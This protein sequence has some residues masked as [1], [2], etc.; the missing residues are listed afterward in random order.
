MVSESVRPTQT[1]ACDPT[2]VAKRI[3]FTYLG[4][5]RSTAESWFGF[6]NGLRL[7]I[8]IDWLLTL[9]LC[10][11]GHDWLLHH[12]L[13][14]LARVRR[15]NFILEFNIIWRLDDSYW[16]CNRFLLLILRFINHGG[17]LNAFTSS[18]LPLWSE[19]IIN[20]QIRRDISELRIPSGQLLRLWIHQL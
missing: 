9:L 4:S 1:R 3:T 8:F 10:D 11:F 6:T 19:S 16:F 14:L 17:F 12:L 2:S 7:H 20:R 13:V 5:F 15:H 18:R